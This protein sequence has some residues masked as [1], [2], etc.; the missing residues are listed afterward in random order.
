M[1]QGLLTIIG[2]PIGAV[3]GLTLSV[4]DGWFDRRIMKSKGYAIDDTLSNMGHPAFLPVSWIILVHVGVACMACFGPVSLVACI[5]LYSIDMCIIT[6]QRNGGRYIIEHI[7]SV[8]EETMHVDP[9][10]A[11]KIAR[12]F[13]YDTFKKWLKSWSGDE[14]LI[15]ADLILDKYA[16]SQR[17][18]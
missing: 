13:Y 1:D 18:C 14:R 15:I 16:E 9:K 5:V 10:E 7:Q 8:V 12:R 4:L 6:P 17:R 11:K 2:I 3:I